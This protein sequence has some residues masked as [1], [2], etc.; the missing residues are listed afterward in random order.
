[1]A[2][3]PSLDEIKRLRRLQ[4]AAGG[5]ADLYRW[6]EIAQQHSAGEAG[7]G[8]LDNPER[9]VNWA[10][11]VILGRGRGVNP[12]P[13]LRA[14]FT[15]LEKEMEANERGSF[16]RLGFGANAEAAYQRVWRKIRKEGRDA[17]ST[18][19]LLIS[20]MRPDLASHLWPLV[21]DF[22][23]STITPDFIDSIK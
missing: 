2:R 14:F 8:A 12:R 10:V 13:T 7:R 15:K 19:I 20:L 18:A 4:N 5:V 6:I 9:L 3:D 23:E 16:Q 22:I 11:E 17:V 1:M 21:S